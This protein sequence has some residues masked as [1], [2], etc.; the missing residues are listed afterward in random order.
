MLRLAHKLVRRAEVDLGRT[1]AAQLAAEW[2]FHY[3]MAGRKLVD[4]SGNVT[5]AA[6]ALHHERRGAEAIAAH[7]VGHHARTLRERKANTQ[8]CTRRGAGGHKRL[9]GGQYGAD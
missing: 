3:A 6:L 1:V 2:A 9:Y 5:A 8:R 7:E 4:A